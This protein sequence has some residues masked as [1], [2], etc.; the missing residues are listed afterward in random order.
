MIPGLDG[1][2]AIAILFVLGTHT[3]NLDF[4]WIGVQLF[5]VLSGFLIT[6]ILLRMKE[7][8]APKAYFT[9]FYGRRFL[10]IFPLYYFYLFLLFGIKFI[11]PYLD[12]KP[13]I[14]EF[15]DKFWAQVWPSIFYVYNFFHASGS[16]EQSRFFTHLWSLSVEEQFYITW[17]FILFLTP[18]DKLKKLFIGAIIL[19]PIIRGI[20]Y[21]V[22]LKHPFPFMIDVP[23]VANYV[24]PFAHI[25]AFAFGAYISQYKIPRPR[26]QFIMAIVIV[27]VIGYLSQYLATGQIQLDTLGQELL[28]SSGYKSIWGYS[29][30][31]YLFAV[32]IYCVAKT[33]LFTRILDSAPLRYLGKISYGFYVYH[34]AVIWFILKFN[35]FF[36]NG[37]LGIYLFAL[38]ITILIASLSFYLL[39][40]PISDL[41]D[42]F[43]PLSQLG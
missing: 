21:I 7:T 40:K 17:P 31:N 19:A 42:K 6:G 39:E 43:F 41:K 3:E 36:E 8:Q 16:Y 30:L 1:L 34:T 35:I 23:E 9:K 2:R 32:M 12:L 37:T 20:L 14:I 18:K 28:L 27:P 25:D 10:R 38:V 4:V 26:L 13:L 5:F 29:L 11:T 22:F 15:G 24:L 33:G